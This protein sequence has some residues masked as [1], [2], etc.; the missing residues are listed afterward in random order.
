MAD[1]FIWQIEDGV[2]AFKIVDTAAVGYARRGTRPP[3]RPRRQDDGRL[4]HRVRIWR[5]Q[6]T[7]GILTPIGRHHHPG[8]PVDVLCERP[9]H[10][11]PEAVDVDVGHRD[12]ARPAGRP[13]P[14]DG[15]RRV[16]LPPRL[17]GGVF[18]PRVERHRPATAGDRPGPHVPDG[19][20][21]GGPHP[22][23]RDGVVAGQPVARHRV[24][25]SPSP[26]GPGRHGLEG[27]GVRVAGSDTIRRWADQVSRF[28]DTWPAD[29]AKVVDETIQARLRADTGGDGGLSGGRNM[30]RATTRVTTGKAQAEVVANG[31]GGCGASLRAAPRPTPSPGPA[32]RCCGPRSGRA[33][34]S[35][36]GD[37]GAAHVQRSRR[38][39]THQGSQGRRA[40]VGQDP[41]R[42]LWPVTPN[43]KPPSPPRT[44]P[45]KSSTRPRRQPRS[46]TARR[47]KRNSTP[48]SPVSSAH[49]IRWPPKPKRPP[50]PP[51]CWAAPSAPN[52]REGE[53]NR[54]RRRPQEHGAHPRPDQGQRRRAGRQDRAELSDTDVGGKLGGSLGT[55]HG[56]LDEVA[57]SADSSKSVLA[58]MVGNATQDLGA[59]GGVAGPRVWR[60]ARWASTWSTP[61]TT[62]TRWATSS[63]T[64]GRSPPRSLRSLWSCRHSGRS[65]RPPG[66]GPPAPRNRC[67]GSPAPCPRQ[68]RQRRGRRSVRPVAALQ[69]RRPHGV[70]RVRRR[71]R[72]RGQGHPA[73]RPRRGR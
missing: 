67:K 38:R 8:R 48:T 73:D 66:N 23:H 54:D 40:G 5:C 27:V 28:A 29:G 9:H 13:V 49:S 70:R 52:Y 56:K 41:G 26:P 35:M 61:P 31:R 22:A 1:P 68:G 15:A 63:R 12:V 20:R 44:T 11:D 39:R 36:C 59:L 32:G 25:S 53:H 72:R 55:T 18:P 65:S 6:V 21:W 14:G 24:G 62:A 30:G 16:H 71:G 10:P 60:S 2:L 57:K 7:S 46:S 69:R 37:S 4:R 64:S 34:R 50:K 45:P 58:N 19:V 42:D 3:A 47:T 51:K 33:A 17:P 43:S